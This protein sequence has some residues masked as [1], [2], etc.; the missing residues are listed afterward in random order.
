MKLEILHAC[1]LTRVNELLRE[2]FVILIVV[3]LKKY[4]YD[5]D[6]L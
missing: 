1:M 6:T 2:Q 4:N 3:Q 5:M